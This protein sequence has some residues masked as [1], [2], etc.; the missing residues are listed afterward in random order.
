M[1]RKLTYHIQREGL[2]W[3]PQGKGE[4]TEKCRGRYIYGWNWK[5]IP[6]TLSEG[7]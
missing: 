1:V 6:K 4:N 7:E 3:N 5:L 2:P